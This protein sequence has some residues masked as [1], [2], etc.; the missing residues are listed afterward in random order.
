ML[1]ARFANFAFQAQ[2]SYNSGMT[3]RENGRDLE[4]ARDFVD[5]FRFDYYNLAQ[6]LAEAR[7]LEEAQDKELVEFKKTVVFDDCP[8]ISVDKPLRG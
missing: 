1:I 7:K 5:Q 4:R 2:P 6:G 3:I 8:K